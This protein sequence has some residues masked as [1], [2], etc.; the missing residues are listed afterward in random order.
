M[1]LKSLA[2]L[3]EVVCFSPCPHVLAIQLCSEPDQAWEMRLHAGTKYVTRVPIC[4]QHQKGGWHRQYD[5][6]LHLVQ[7][8][9]HMTSHGVIPPPC[10]IKYDILQILTEMVALRD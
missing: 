7:N 8:C 6:T 10:S 1:E 9:Q 4:A 5:V 2:C 3:Q